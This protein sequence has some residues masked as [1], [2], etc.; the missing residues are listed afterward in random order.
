M[1][2][3][4]VEVRLGLAATG[5]RHH[6]GALQGPQLV[7]DLGLDVRVRA[8][9]QSLRHR[10]VQSRRILC[11]WQARRWKKAS[12]GE[13]DGL[14]GDE[15]SDWAEPSLASKKQM[16]TSFSWSQARAFKVV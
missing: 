16:P 12:G 13:S 14:C 5:G 1:L 11:C 4:R 3:R 15:T 9:L 10:R 6:C 7:E 8:K 2:I